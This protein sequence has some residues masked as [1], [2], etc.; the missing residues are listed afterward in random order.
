MKIRFIGSFRLE[1][2]SG[3]V[4]GWPRIQIGAGCKIRAGS[5]WLYP[6]GSWKPPRRESVQPPWA[7]YSTACL[8]SW[9][10]SCSDLEASMV[11]FSSHV[12][13]LQLL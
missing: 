7:A 5:S 1:G 12:Y 10:K 9:W 6:T 13:V 11:H 2:C 3:V 4:L 8:S